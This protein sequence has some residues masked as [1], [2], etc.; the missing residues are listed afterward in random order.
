MATLRPA[1][2]MREMSMTNVKNKQIAKF[3]FTA[4]VLL[5]KRKSELK[6]RKLVS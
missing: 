4:C 1:L 3:A 5:V 6:K 2:T